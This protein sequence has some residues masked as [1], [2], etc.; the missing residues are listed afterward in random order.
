MYRLFVNYIKHEYFNLVGFYVVSS[1]KRYQW[2]RHKN[3]ISEA[4]C[5]LSDITRR[6]SNIALDL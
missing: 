3:L 5:M 4:T 2:S 1:T 6:I